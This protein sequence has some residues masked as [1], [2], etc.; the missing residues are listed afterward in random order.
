MTGYGAKERVT[1]QLKKQAP[2]FAYFQEAQNLDLF[3][4]FIALIA[5]LSYGRILFFRDVFWDDNCWLLST[6]A[7]SNLEQFLNTGF[8]EVRRVPMGIFLYNLF[9]LH[10]I[11]E[12]T[13]LIWHTMNIIIQVAT[14]V[15]LYLFIKNFSKE[16]QLLSL[17]IGITFIIFPL[18]Y[19]LPYLSAIIYRIATLFTVI[20]F[21]LT[22]RAFAKEK[23]RFFFLF[24]SLLLSG[25]SHYVFMELTVVFEL[26]RLFVIGYIM[27]RKGY[28][29]KALIKK[30]VVYSMPFLILFV[31][32]TIYKL[33]FKPYGIYDGVYK[34]DFLF[35]LKIG[36]HE[37]LLRVLLLQQWKLLM[38]YIKDTSLWSIVLSS[39]A[40]AFSGFVLLRMVMESKERSVSIGSATLEALKPI[41]IV[42]SLFF[43]FPV[44]LLEFTGREIGF[45]FNS[46]HFNQLQIGYAIIVGSL[47]YKLYAM[48]LGTHVEKKWITFLAVIL[49][50]LG[51]F[52]NNLNL[53]LYIKATDKQKQFWRAFTNRF[54]SLPEGTTIMMDVREF[55]YFDTPDLDNAYDLELSLNLLYTDSMEP[56]KFHK[57]K[58][59]AYEE[60]RPGMTES[61]KCEG[62]D[63]GRM[64][65]MTHLGKEELDPCKFIVVYYRNGEL[66][67]NREIKEKHPDIPYGRWLDKAFPE[68]PEPVSYP[69]RHKFRGLDNA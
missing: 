22:V 18:D 61:I 37:K 4:L 48:F 39:A 2:R 28:T 8:Y 34:T 55:Y 5:V 3:P 19:T 59:F 42:G 56:D 41:L 29:N 58:A 46:S 17:I 35:F 45:G 7:S 36:E 23:P 57:Y 24:I 33:M 30:T 9:K 60:F 68:L 44:L 43:I 32:L 14:P 52:F 64:E 66:L 50:G 51:V 40:A 47:L 62:S 13:H 20:S 49:I 15:F 27:H 31:P 25:L 53:D 26:A 21:Y 65:R 12:N 54:P 6:Y 1:T 10:K 38:G 11:T 63:E 69:L 67:V 16:R